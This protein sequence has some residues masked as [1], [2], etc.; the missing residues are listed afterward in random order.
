MPI[1]EV[2]VQGA[3]YEVDAPDENTAWVWANASH[4]Q[5]AAPQPAPAQAPQSPLSPDALFAPAPTL[6]PIPSTAPAPSTTVQGL[7]GAATRGV[8]P[9]ALGAGAG[10]ALGAP[11]AGV[12][13]VPGAAVGA[14]AVALSTLI[15][16]PLIRTIN[17]TL[18]TQFTEPTTALEN[19]FTQLGVAQPKSAAE[20][21]L[22]T[23]ISAAGGA[24]AGA[25][26]GKALT[27]MAP[28]GSTTALVGEAMAAQPLQQVLSGAGAGA[29]Q[30]TAAE[31]GADPISQALAALIG[32]GVGFTAGA[33]RSPAAAKPAPTSAAA[34]TQTQQAPRAPLPAEQQMPMID[35][36]STAKAAARG[37]EES[38]AMKTLATQASPDPK[39]VEA[40]KR[41]GIEEHLQPDHVSSNQAF[42]ELAQAVKSVPGSTARAAEIQGLEAVAQKAD[43]L[44]SSLGGKS[45]GNIDASVRSK[46]S[47]TIDE[48]ET[49]ANELYDTLRANVNAKTETPAE[50]VLSFIRNKADDLGGEQNL[51]QLEQTV[52]A[53][54]GPKQ[55]K[56]AA[57][58]VVGTKQPT[59]ALVDDVRKAVGEA[60]RGKGADAFKDA[61]R[62]LAKKLYSL[63][64][65]DQGS[66]LRQLGMEDTF[67]A[68]RAAVK[69]RKGVE[70]DMMSIFG[71]NLQKSMVDQLTGAMRSLS[72]GDSAKLNKL[73]AAIP[74]DMRKDVVASGLTSAFNRANSS[75]P[76][77]FSSY[78]DW[79]EGL[80]KN[81]PA[82]TALMTN[83]P[84]E[85]RKNLS[86]LYRVSKGIRDSVSRER[87]TTGRLQVVKEELTGGETLMQR[88][89]E[90][91]KP[92][93]A[94]L[95]TEAVTTMFGAPGAGLGA[96]FVQGM[97]KK[98]DTLLAAD[99]VFASHQ[100]RKLAAE[101]AAKGEPSASS[102]RSLIMLPSFKK[103]ANKVQLPNDP[104]SLE[105]WVRN[106]MLPMAQNEEQL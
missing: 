27:R 102:I 80:L 64:E 20:K 22:Q 55:V 54:L 40:A 17:S 58:N 29:A 56:D 95:A 24:G 45:P 2:D 94:K 93:G 23:T 92:T 34:P 96:A 78:T 82:M 7:I 18:G 63:L 81:K 60:A 83:L 5:S 50:N 89:I 84:S 13:A 41:L 100:F 49:K 59:Y 8:G 25:A 104:A 70:D 52:L 33:P 77:N 4:T 97:T 42:R 73:I 37:G 57:G 3:T 79:Y 9:V 88:M 6:A 86:D 16:D 85:A 90:A 26:F 87:I 11:I 30:Q 32:G 76:I 43:D 61:D 69:M 74:E 98:T 15:G 91:A 48:L 68:A 36:A 71:K 62:G 44:V 21:V 103:F 35:L 99:A 1:F 75:K 67:N 46:M 39:I 14:G 66:V 53:K 47:S 51:S 38:S 101:A 72:K 31:A 105:R 106:S 28:A 12:G 65:D 10:A 19:L